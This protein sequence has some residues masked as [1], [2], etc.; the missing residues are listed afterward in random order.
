MKF[1]KEMSNFEIFLR[2]AGVIWGPGAEAW[3]LQHRLNAHTLAE[4]PAAVERDGYEICYADLPERVS[5]FAQVIEGKPV[6]VVNRD[7]SPQHRQYT[8]AHEV[9]HHLLHLNPNPDPGL[10]EFSDPDLAE[11][12]AHMFAAAMVVHVKDEKEREDLLKQ[13]R[14][15]AAYLFGAVFMTIAVIIVLVVLHLAS[16]FVPNQPSDQPKANG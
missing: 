3:K 9:G 4:I 7:K 15:P 6:I 10:R 16:F 12:Q 8:V 2:V 11:Y 5:G 1:E 13:N 14:E